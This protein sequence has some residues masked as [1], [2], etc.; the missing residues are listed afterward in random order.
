MKI[1]KKDQVMYQG[2]VTGEFK[3]WDVIHDCSE[4]EKDPSQAGVDGTNRT[5]PYMPSWQA[6]PVIPGTKN[7]AYNWDLPLHKQ[8]AILALQEKHRVVIME[9]YMIPDYTD[10]ELLAETE[11]CTA[12]VQEAKNE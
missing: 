7:A 2:P 4:F 11:V 1:Q 9:A 5:G 3:Y 6:S 10:P 12:H 8:P